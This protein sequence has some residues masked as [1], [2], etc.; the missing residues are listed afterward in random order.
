MKASTTFANTQ[1]RVVSVC[2]S[3]IHPCVK[4]QKL[5]PYF[6]FSI[7]RNCKDHYSFLV[8]RLCFMLKT[9]PFEGKGEMVALKMAWSGSPVNYQTNVMSG[10]EPEITKPH[11]AMDQ[12]SFDE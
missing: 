1:S 3:S 10:V 7:I 9:A 12:F 8:I 2:R 11:G 5:L 4:Q 6:L